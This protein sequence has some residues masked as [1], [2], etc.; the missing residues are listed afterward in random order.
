MSLVFELAAGKQFTSIQINCLEP[1]VEVRPHQDEKNSGS[2]Y[3]MC[4][5]EYEGGTL[6]VCRNGQYQSCH[7]QHVWHKIRE[8]EEHYVEAVRSAVRWSLVL[9]CPTGWE[10]LDGAG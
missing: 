6:R 10:K 3:I 1:G 9:Y 4:F 2:S 5:G 7:E 8:K